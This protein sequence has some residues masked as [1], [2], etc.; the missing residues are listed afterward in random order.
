MSMNVLI[1]TI[2][3]C[4]VVATCESFSPIWLCHLVTAMMTKLI[5]VAIIGAGRI[6]SGAC[7][8]IRLSIDRRV[9][10]YFMRQVRR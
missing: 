4:V 10:G 7:S 1:V 3:V 6:T 2:A 8:I 9:I 5:L